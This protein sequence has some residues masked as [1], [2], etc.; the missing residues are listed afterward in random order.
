M[1]NEELLRSF[2]IREYFFPSSCS[3]RSN[4]Q[5]WVHQTQESLTYSQKLPGA[6]EI[7]FPRPFEWT[8]TFIE[9]HIHDDSVLGARSFAAGGGAIGLLE[10]GDR[11][12]AA[13]AGRAG[14]AQQGGGHAGREAGAAQPCA[15]CQ[16]HHTLLELLERQHRTAVR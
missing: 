4:G 1:K 13:G 10:A 8:L 6:A 14:A 2:C 12:A 11:N 15:H 16:C 5:T 3:S 9:C 7:C